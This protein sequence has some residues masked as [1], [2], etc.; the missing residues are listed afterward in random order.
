MDQKKCP[1]CG[2]EKA[3]SQ[4][5][6][7]SKNGFV[8]FSEDT[9]T[10]ID[11]PICGFFDIH[12]ALNFEEFPKIRFYPNL[13]QDAN[14]KFTEQE[15]IINKALLRQAVFE[16]APK[17]SHTIPLKVNGTFAR[18]VFDR[19]FPTPIE[20]VWYLVRFLGDTLQYAGNNYPYT[21]IIHP[22]QLFS[23]IAGLNDENVK[24]TIANAQ[25]LGLLYQNPTS[26]SL[27]IQGWQK[28]EELKKGISTSKSIFMA[29][30]FDPEQR[31]FIDEMLKPLVKKLG[32]ELNLLTDIASKENLIDI[33]LR[34]SILD[35]I[36]LICDLTHRNNGAYFEAG[37]AEGNGK[38]VIYIYEE[39]SF[40]DRKTN[41]IHFDVEHL[42][43]Y[44]WKKDD[45]I[46][47][48]K[49]LT[50]IEAK[51]TATLRI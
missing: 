23:A 3:R 8:N 34:N 27:T 26:L 21:D 43:T 17:V 46:S 49:F 36:M 30:Q 51:I 48:A 20:Q 45:E 42:E 16:L 14:W 32:F 31:H 18:E 5:N 47:I 19:H 15:K 25:E 7:S 37:F 2:Y 11:C 12:G 39:D 41:K 24:G 33:K 35:S 50:D 1:I 29:M 38:P 10:F 40:K 4:F 9:N 28:Y 13:S 6:G 44:Q 22:K